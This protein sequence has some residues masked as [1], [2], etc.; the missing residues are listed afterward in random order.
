MVNRLWEVAKECNIEKPGI[1]GTSGRMMSFVRCGNVAEFMNIAVQ[2]C[3]AERNSTEFPPMVRT[4]HTH[5][6]GRGG[7]NS[8]GSGSNKTTGGGRR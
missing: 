2:K 8:T 6:G 4:K 1:A 5:S 3:W 7:T